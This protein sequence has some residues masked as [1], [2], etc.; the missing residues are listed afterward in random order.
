MCNEDKEYIELEIVTRELDLNNPEELASLNRAQGYLEEFLNKQQDDALIIN[1]ADNILSVF[2][3]LVC[4]KD[5]LVLV[6]LQLY[7]RDMEPINQSYR[8]YTVSWEQAREIFDSYG[9]DG[10]AEAD[11]DNDVKFEMSSEILAE[12][13]WEFTEDVRSELNLKNLRIAMPKDLPVL[14]SNDKWAM[15]FGKFLYKEIVDIIENIEL[16][17]ISAE[18]LYDE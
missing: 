12:N 17:D 16:I 10:W 15:S 2:S 7:K 5:N 8:T 18:D 1:N 13:M 3:I 4:G 11:L 9:N 6:N 14:D